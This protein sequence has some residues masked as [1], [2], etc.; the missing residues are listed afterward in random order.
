M[1]N[2]NLYDSCKL[3]PHSCGVNRNTGVLGYCKTSSK[4]HIS[5]ICIHRGE[6]PI[7]SGK[8][9]ICNIFFSHCNMQCIFCQNHQIS[10]NTNSYE[11]ILS[12]TEVV[13]EITAFLNKGIKR[14]GFV[15]P[16]H[17]VLQVIDIIEQL[18]YR[19]YKPITVWNSNAY[20]NVETLR[21]LEPYIDVYLPD[22]KYSDNRLA[23]EFSGCNNY[24]EIALAAIKEMYYQKGNV[25]HLDNNNEIEKGLIIRHLVLP[26]HVENSLGVLETIA[27]EISPRVYISLMSQYYPPAELN[28][29]IK[30]NRYLNKEEYITVV[31]YME[32]LGL[33]NGWIQEFESQNY[34]RPDFYQ[35]HPFENN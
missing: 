3:C 20:D 25:I 13:N 19:D 6:E 1:I 28:L 18:W 9:G 12:T 29:P 17:M 35:L 10:R 2:Y 21:I 24:F 23:K 31:E 34:Y 26:N 15:S 14:L 33:T 30:I 8:D 7:I 5:S 16:S 32:Y 22:F 4:Q 27:N 11:K